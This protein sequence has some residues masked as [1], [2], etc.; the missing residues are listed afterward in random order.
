M[1]KIEELPALQ[2]KGTIDFDARRRHTMDHN[3]TRKSSQN[4]EKPIG[5][6]AMIEILKAKPKINDKREKS[7][8]EV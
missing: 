2:K 5:D 8:D 6:H 3:T 1:N 7:E 4:L